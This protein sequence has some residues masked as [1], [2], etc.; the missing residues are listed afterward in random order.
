ML[1]KIIAA[2]L[3]AFQV[4]SALNNSSCA[5]PVHQE[6]IQNFFHLQA[7]KIF[8]DDHIEL[9]I[10]KT[11]ESGNYEPEFSIT[12]EKRLEGLDK[13]TVA[14]L[15]TTGTDSTRLGKHLRSLSAPASAHLTYYGGRINSAVQIIQVMWG[16]GSYEPHL[17][18]TSV[19][20]MAS[21]LQAL[22]YDGALTSWLNSEYTTPNQK[23]GCG[24]FAGLYRITP[25]TSAKSISDTVIKAELKAQI[26]AGKLPPPQ[27][28]SDDNPVSYYAVFFPAG[29]TITMGWYSSCVSGG[30]CAYHGTVA[31]SNG[32]NQ[33]YYAVQPDFQSN[34]CTTGC[35]YSSTMFEN[36]C[37]V[38]SH[39]LVEMLTDPEVGLNILSWYDN[40]NGE[41]GDMCNAQQASY[42]A[43]DGYTY[44]IQKEFSNEQKDCVEFPPSAKFCMP[45]AYPSMEPTA[46]TALPTLAPTTPT[47][48]PT[49]APTRPT[50]VPTIVPTK[51]P[52]CKP[53]IAPS[54]PT[55][56]P[57]ISPTFKGFLCPLYNASDTNYGWQNTVPC[58]F[59]SCPGAKLAISACNYFGGGGCWG[60]DW[61]YI[62]LQYADGKEITN[63][64]YYYSY[65]CKTGCSTLYYTIPATEPCQVYRIMQGCWGSGPNSFCSGQYFINAGIEVSPPSVLSTLQPS[66]PT[67]PPTMEP[68]QPSNQPT[69]ITPT[70]LPTITPTQPTYAPT[71]IAPTFIPSIVPTA[72]SAIPTA[73]TR[74]PTYVPSAVPTG[75]PFL[76]PFF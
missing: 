69:T 6:I 33:F 22:T 40:T 13:Y 31:S 15:Q 18:T 9:S 39:E 38:A 58:Y 72:P 64:N 57:S 59:Y 61:T 8:C 52:S 12:K 60:G 34:G 53:T 67:V 19:P 74:I 70:V 35:G 43:C 1:S 50:A 71:S 63:W 51:S 62:H 45:T 11:I 10:S 56:Q 25:S 3:S 24:N 36:M 73:P 37:S 65:Y 41:I 26:N 54:V 30:F 4:V 55:Q 29:V 16:P 66:T 32:F 23:F 14:K 42:L 46:P 2:I 68:T 17:N 5:A 44:R 21:F 20:S 27:L 76:C 47:M 7:T 75:S 48:T 28:D 49:Q